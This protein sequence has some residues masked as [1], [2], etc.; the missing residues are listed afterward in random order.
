MIWY[1][2]DI[3][4]VIKL[5]LDLMNFVWFFNFLISL[6]ILKSFFYLCDVFHL[7]LVNYSFSY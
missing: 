2:V 1:L 4:Y 6:I 5:G 7:T 3:I